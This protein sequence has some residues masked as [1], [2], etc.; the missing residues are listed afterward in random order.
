M[1]SF[2]TLKSLTN[3]GCPIQALLLGLSGTRSTQRNYLSAIAT[4][5]SFI[6]FYEVLTL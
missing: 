3:V 6:L 5:F 2:P 1:S 4:P